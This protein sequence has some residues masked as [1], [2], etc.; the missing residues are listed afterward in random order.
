MKVCGQPWFP[1]DLKLKKFLFLSL[2]SRTVTLLRLEKEELTVRRRVCGVEV[3]V[4]SPGVNGVSGR[5]FVHVPIR[6]W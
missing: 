1:K 5:T 3:T 2:N 4:V 6:V